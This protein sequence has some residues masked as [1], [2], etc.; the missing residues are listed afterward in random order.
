MGKYII[1]IK[2]SKPEEIDFTNEF[3][4]KI[5]T[6]P[7]IDKQTGQIITQDTPLF[8]EWIPLNYILVQIEI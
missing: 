2:D 8:I 7:Q 1:I 3:K 5:E 6:I 4:L